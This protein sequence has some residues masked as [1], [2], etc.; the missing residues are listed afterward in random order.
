MNR[1]PPRRVDEDGHKIDIDKD[2]R[3]TRG[4]RQGYDEVEDSKAS[5]E[6]DTEAPPLTPRRHC[7]VIPRK[8]D[9]EQ[10]TTILNNCYKMWHLN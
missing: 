6:G 4:G 2:R 3:P 9:T 10:W 1:K 8:G 5:Q 7:V